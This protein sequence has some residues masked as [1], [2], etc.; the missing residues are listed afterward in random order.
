MAKFSRYVVV[1]LRHLTTILVIL[2]MNLSLQLWYHIIGKQ[3]FQL[4]KSFYLQVWNRMV[5]AQD[6]D[7]VEQQVE[8][9]I[10]SWEA[11]RSLSCSSVFFK[12]CHSYRSSVAKGQ[13]G[14]RLERAKS[15]LTGGLTFTQVTS[16]NLVY[17]FSQYKAPPIGELSHKWYSN[18]CSWTV[19]TRKFER[20]EGKKNGIR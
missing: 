9:L 12:I 16:Q 2:I 6:V 10:R 17:F 14:A 3:M 20:G 15:E 4:A 18:V 5:E 19:P 11:P 8:D 7:L 13:R 1:F